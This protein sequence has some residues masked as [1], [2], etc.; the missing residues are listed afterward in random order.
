M[1]SSE[2]TFYNIKRLHLMFVISATALLAVTVWM[3]AADH[4]RPW[5]QY[6]RTF[7][8]RIE[9]W[10][11]QV[12]INRQRDRQLD[13][14]E[15]ELKAALEKARRAVPDEASIAEFRTEV[16]EDAL[17]REAREPDFA[18]LQA[19]CDE[20]AAGASVAARDAALAELWQ[21]INATDLRQ[22]SAERR[23][24]FRRAEFDQARSYY[25]AAVGQRRPQKELDRL[26]Q[27][28][29]EVAGDV[30]RLTAGVEQ[31]A[32]HRQ[33]LERILARVTRE[34]DVARKEL[35]DRRTELDRLER[36][37]A[38]QH[39]SPGKRFLRGP[40]IDA[41]GRPLAIEQ[42]WLPEL[43]IDYNFQPVA[44][45]DRCTTCHLGI[46]KTQPGEPSRPAFG[47]EQTITVELATPAK[48]PEPKESDDGRHAPPTL[49]SVYGL[50]LAARGVLDADAATVERVRRETP[51][52]DA[53]LRTGDLIAKIGG[54]PIRDRTALR[55]HLLEEV[56]WGRP[57]ELEIRRG[58]PH[59]YGAH[60]RLDLFVGS[61]SPHPMAEFG[62]T[63]CHDGQGSATEF[64]FASHTPNDPTQRV[65][66]RDRH[67]WF[68]NE[69][70]D[71][72]M[73]PERFAQSRCLKC[74]HA[75]TD[76]EPG[77]R[78][79]EP[80][81]P[82]LLAGYHLI[83]QNGCFGCHEIRGFS[84]SGRSIGPDMR[85]EPNYAAAALELLDGQRPHPGTMRKVGPT[86]RG[87]DGKLG[88]EFLL[89]WIADPANFL[90]DARMPQFYGMHEH[91]D[92][93]GLNDAK[94]FEPVESRAMV[95]YLLT[96]GPSVEPIPVPAEVTE[97]PDAARGRTLFEMHGCLAC[98]KHADFPEGKAVQGPNLTNVGAKFTIEAGRRWLVDWIRDPVRHSPR[99]LMPNLLLEPI[100]LPTPKEDGDQAE[101]TDGE[102]ATDAPASQPRITDPAADVAAYLLQGGRWKA[103][104][105]PP[106][107]T[108]DLDELVLLH[109][110]ESFPGNLARQYRANGIPEELAGQV[111]VDAAELLGE[112]TQ[113]KKLRYVGRRTIRKRGCYGC[114]DV[115]GFEDAQPI[116]PALT[117]WGRKQESLLAF[118]QINRFIEQ[119]GDPNRGFFMEA[120]LSHRREGFLW[121][122]LRAPRS[123]DF[124]KAHNKG[125]NARLTMGRFDLTDRQ[126]EAIITFVLG[127]VAEPPAEKYV[128][129]PDP[130]QKAIAEGRKVLDKY[131]CAECH[132]L[133]LERWS[134]EFAP[135]ELEDPPEMEDY[136]F[137]EPHFAPDEIAASALPDDRGLG[138][139]EVAGMRQVDG[140]G[141]LLD[142]DDDVDDHGNEG[143]QYG[144][145]LWEPAAINGRVWTVGG[146]DLLLWGPEADSKD[147]PAGRLDVS[148]FGSRITGVRPPVG[149]A[150]A[151]LLYPAALAAGRAAGANPQGP[152][153]RG[154]VPPPLVHEGAKVQ[155]AWLYD[156]LLAPT[157]IRPAS[158]LRMPRYNMS[159]AEAG[160]L[161][162]YFAAVSGVDFPYSSHPG[163]N[164]AQAEGGEPG[165]LDDAMKLLLDAKT[166]CAKCHLIGDYS[167]GG[168][169]RTTMAPNL[170]RVGRR[171]RPEFLRRWLANPKSVLPYTAMTVNFPPTGDPLEP[172]LFD[173]NTLEQIEA[174]RALLLNYDWYLRSRT[175]V[176]Q[177]VKPDG[178]SGKVAPGEDD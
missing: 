138:T 130:P 160:K 148:Y 22:T 85:L 6:Q 153:A 90:P 49:E 106:W 3:L 99:T 108:K 113:R 70:W 51:A 11:T 43:T 136:D 104:E 159:G 42:I 145:T 44:R 60:P 111:Q 67:G 61:L 98:H 131:A 82:K 31:A 84:E 37:L 21:F 152:E 77:P 158:V 86:L 109:L 58:L 36:A 103:R 168:E 146:V 121:Q 140:R 170:D 117:Q 118:E 52:A 50:V 34:E 164:A 12:Q 87:I 13:A 129:N 166:D 63:I 100:P 53:R 132:V 141:R 96:S 97:P 10:I 114:H 62:C 14:R 4:R 161:V 125:Y 23:L 88:R 15:E 26:Q 45:F 80:P 72:P 41:L 174:V 177:L 133:E 17:R 27:K 29:D 167:P 76:L 91:L 57:L 75:V 116:G 105:L 81:A 112:M 55:K 149:G 5:K 120:L 151:R 176:E 64:K 169:V 8:D 139:A 71:F 144:F 137:L 143:F 9:P 135:D 110:S 66:W 35:A 40:L 83:R 102:E 1:R 73:L 38:E 128:W 178:G 122:K 19:A 7:R 28:V 123:F 157:P 154:W 162:D 126:R 156:Y 175:A 74:H 59:P 33:A 2:K 65:G 92:G 32:A 155:P 101:G 30:N 69:H 163:G 24:R 68:H 172:D 134:F 47:A 39:P 20:S 150:A 56:E 173:G 171:I 127:L 48:A 94:R 115:P 18:D 107:K 54:K 25:E 95:E 46:D 79:P 16:E 78:Y 124:K 89:D 93:R 119:S 147:W 142:L 165:R